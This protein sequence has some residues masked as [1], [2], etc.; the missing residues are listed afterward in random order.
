MAKS[1]WGKVYFKDTY[2]GRLQEEPDGRSIFT[3][4]ESYLAPPSSQCSQI[5]YSFPLR[6]NPFISE[7]GLHPFLII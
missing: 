3:Y 1:L 7:N 2:A 4:D 5:S 6:K